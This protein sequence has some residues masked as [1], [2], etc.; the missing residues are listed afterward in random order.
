MYAH[1]FATK[2]EKHLIISETNRPVGKKIIVK[3]KPEAR[4]IAKEM[5]IKPWNF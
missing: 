3:S 2:N 5:N 4:K 1:Y